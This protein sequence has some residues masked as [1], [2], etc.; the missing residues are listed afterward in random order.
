MSHQVFL[1]SDA[2][3]DILEIYKYVS[4]NDSIQSAND[5]FDKLRETC[6]SLAKLPKR[7][8]TPSELER[9]SVHEF[10]EIHYKPYRI[11][12]EISDNCV[13]IH[14]IIDGR[15]DLQELLQQRLLR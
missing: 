13:Y 2:E 8:H 10:K 12:Y 15:R 7:G 5:L 4:R 14:C 11:I 3:D 6:Y 9:I 1:V